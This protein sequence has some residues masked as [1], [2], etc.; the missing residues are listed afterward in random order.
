[1]EK[2]CLIRHESLLSYQVTSCGGFLFFHQI[3]FDNFWDTL[4]EDKPKLTRGLF[5]YLAN[6]LNLQAQGKGQLY[7]KLS[8]VTEMLP[9][10]D[11]LPGCQCKYHFIKVSRFFCPVYDD[12]DDRYVCQHTFLNL[13][14]HTLPLMKLWEN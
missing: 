12:S 11:H 1:M 10:D 7:Y 13:N 8:K 3:P 14:G 6:C 5:D 2:N 4:K 9:R